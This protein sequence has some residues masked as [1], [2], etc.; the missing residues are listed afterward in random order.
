MTPSDISVIIPAINEAERLGR[1]IASAFD[2]GAGEVIV[3][4]GGSR[5]GSAEV[6][7][8]AGAAVIHSRAGRGVQQN[9]GAA[10][11]RGEVLL[12]LHADNWLAPACGE[13]I[14]SALPQHPSRW[15]G[16]LRQRIA[17]DRLSLRLIAWGD[18]CRVRWRGI[19]FGDQGIFIRRRIFDQLDGFP[20]EPLMEDLMLA[21][22]LRRIAWP[23]LLPGPIHVDPRRWDRQGP[24]RQ[25]V[26]NLSLQ[27][28]HAWG[29]TPSE[30][31]R[32]Y[33]RHDGP[34]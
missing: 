10:A 22:R 1:A 23:L 11:S 21:V 16:A 8:D 24:L 7:E 19:P 12:F 15:G 20:D 30:L 34:R 2:A 13:Q 27:L 26:R 25:T 17:S 29:A 33:P 14:A 18:S 4:D 5:D 31:V 28:R 9:V 32:H 3:V 6:A